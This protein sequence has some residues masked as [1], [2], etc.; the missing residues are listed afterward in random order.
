MI[1]GAQTR[2]GQ[3]VRGGSRLVSM[4]FV[5][6]MTA[7]NATRADSNECCPQPPRHLTASAAISGDFKSSEQLTKLEP[8]GIAIQ[9]AEH[10]PPSPQPYWPWWVGALALGLIAPT[11]WRVTGA[12]FGV[13]GSWDKLAHCRREHTRSL[14]EAQVRTASPDRIADAVMAET[15]AEF[16]PEAINSVAVDPTTSAPVVAQ[17]PRLPLLAHLVFIAMIALGGVFAAMASDRF[18]LS[19]DLGPVHRRLFG[20]GIVMWIVLFMGGVITGFG[21]RLGGGCTSGHGLTGLSC[22][23]FGSIVSTACFFGTAIAVS[24][25]LEALR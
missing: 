3:R 6:G 21:A 19:F 16:G 5:V 2:L 1:I 9:F 17:Q 15:L 8:S 12:P 18:H 7:A 11:F 23:Q 22:L 25:A 14:Q 4:I 10:V 24:F 20:D 13:S